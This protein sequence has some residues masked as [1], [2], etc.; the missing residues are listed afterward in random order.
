M[1]QLNQSLPTYSASYNRYLSLSEE[2]FFPSTSAHPGRVRCICGCEHV[3]G[4]FVRQLLGATPSS[5][6][7]ERRVFKVLIWPSCCWITGLSL[8]LSL[9]LSAHRILFHDKYHY[10]KLLKTGN[11]LNITHSPERIHTYTKLIIVISILI[12]IQNQLIQRKRIGICQ[13]PD[14]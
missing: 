2:Q 8:S 7:D 6:A 12:I 1:K 13:F 9:S 4:L 5:L 11:Y 3:T 14:S 10:S